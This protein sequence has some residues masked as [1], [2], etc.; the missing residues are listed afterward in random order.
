MKLNRK[1]KVLRESEITEFATLV[2]NIDVERNKLMS[3]K[4]IRE[5]ML[6]E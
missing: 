4:K 2:N 3:N 5:E 1:R 6:D